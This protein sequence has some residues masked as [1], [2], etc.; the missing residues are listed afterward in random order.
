ME[1]NDDLRFVPLDQ[2]P[3][4]E[5]A[6]VLGRGYEGYMVPLRFTAA[7]LS[8]RLRRD[9]VDLTQSYLIADASGREHGA[10]LVAR[11]GREARIAAIGLAP[12][13]RG[14]GL[15]RQAM[16]R[17][18]EDAVRRGDHRIVLEVISSNDPARRLY[19]SCGF[20]P[21][22][23]LVGYTWQGP[24]SSESGEPPLPGS[25]AEACDLDQ[26][27]G[28]LLDAYPPSASWQTAPVSFAAA[29]LPL[30]AFRS[31]DGAVALVE[32][33]GERMCLLALAVAPERR[34]QGVARAFML[35]LF[36]R[37]GGV[38]WTIPAFVPEALGGPFFTGCGWQR[39]ELTQVE[40]ELRLPASAAGHAPT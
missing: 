37:F 16:A 7:A 40:M 10:M 12:E 6:A 1:G 8:T 15:G 29:T 14:R 20:T 13:S 5:I 39:S 26:V 3:L 28:P 25:A 34:R 32:P 33:A 36:Q 22:R 2:F 17:A 31:A 11:R 23:S 4:T 21:L 19:E 38:G 35:S 24:S 27:L 9:H 30:L 18:T